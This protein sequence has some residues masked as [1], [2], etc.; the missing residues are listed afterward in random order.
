MD[1]QVV[2][3][4]SPQFPPST[5]MTA[6]SLIRNATLPGTCCAQAGR[7]EHQREEARTWGET[8]FKK[9]L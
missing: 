4:E 5:L 2:L 3:G 9:H 8:L 1:F 7:S 6:L